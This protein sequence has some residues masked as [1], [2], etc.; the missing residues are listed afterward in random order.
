MKSIGESSQQSLAFQF[1]SFIQKRDHEGN[2]QAAA[3]IV[4]VKQEKEG[5]SSTKSTTSKLDTLPGTMM[6]DNDGI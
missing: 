2:E 6:S 3:N 5:G 1:D 4:S